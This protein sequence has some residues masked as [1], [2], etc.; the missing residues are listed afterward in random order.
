MFFTFLL[1]LLFFC[2]FKLFSK[3]IFLLFDYLYF[4]ISVLLPKSRDGSGTIAS[5]LKDEKK[6]SSPTRSMMNPPLRPNLTP[7]MKYMNIGSLRNEVGPLIDEL[8]RV[9]C[10][11][12]EQI[13]EWRIERNHLRRLTE[14][15]SSSTTGNGLDG[16]SGMV[17]NSLR[18]NEEENK[19]SEPFI[20]NGKLKMRLV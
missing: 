2:F 5:R 7:Q 8:M 17:L 11:T 12:I 13:E 15:V 1:F 20:Y 19:S 10:E 16:G 6:D 4:L 3:L 18:S 9:T 14:G